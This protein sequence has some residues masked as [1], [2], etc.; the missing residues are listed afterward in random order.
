MWRVPK[1]P[2]KAVAR[3]TSL[4]EWGW[5]WLIDDFARRE[6]VVTIYPRWGS[7]TWESTELSQSAITRTIDYLQVLSYRHQS[8]QYIRNFLEA[9]FKKEQLEY[10]YSEANGEWR[11]P[12]SNFSYHV[13]RPLKTTVESLFD[14]LERYSFRWL[15]QAAHITM[16]FTKTL[17]SF[18]HDFRCGTSQTQQRH[19]PSHTNPIL[20]SSRHLQTWYATL[21]KQSASKYRSGPL[22][23]WTRYRFKCKVDSS[24]HRS[25]RKLWEE[26]NIMSLWYAQ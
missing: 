2:R 14:L 12:S 5:K 23:K 25:G 17:N 26:G 22:S 19:T 8:S 1:C 13:K 16:P 4:M 3:S 20:N 18:V 24:N 9:S 11:F 15:S 6:Q 21:S 7:P 10:R